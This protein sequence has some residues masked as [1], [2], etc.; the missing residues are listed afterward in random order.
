MPVEDLTPEDIKAGLDSGTMLLIDVRE[1]AEYE[2]ERIPGALLHALSTF[3]PSAMPTDAD[4]R[5]IL[6][7]KSGGRSARAAEACQAAGVNVTGHMA[8]GI[9]AWKEAGFPV[10]R[11][12]PPTGQIVLAQDGA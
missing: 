6:H 1:P 12:D 7:C 9:G 11:M 10:F 2:A 8:G 4:R 3:D 5:V